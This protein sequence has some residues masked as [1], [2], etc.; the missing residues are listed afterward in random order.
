MSGTVIPINPGIEL[1]AIENHGSAVA[2]LVDAARAHRILDDTSRGMAADIRGALKQAERRIDDTRTALVKPLNDHV[3]AI[4]VR[5]KPMSDALA[6]AV[7]S[8]DREIIRDRRE[9]EAVAERERRRLS[10]EA[11]TKRLEAE[12]EQRRRAKEAAAKAEE[13]ARALGMKD[14]EARELGALY[15]ADEAAKPLPPV[16]QAAPPPPPA[17]VIVSSAGSTAGVSK[18][19]DFELLDVRALAAAYPET[20]EVRRAKVLDLARAFEREG[21]PEKDIERA[22]PGVR[23]FKRDSVSG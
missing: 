16:I 10:A 12:E 19:W 2:S 23:A 14:A 17:R 18:L 6:Q 1:A 11:E 5:F 21:V 8:I 13:E 20:V 4:N 7:E 22:I 3:K 15:H 9:R